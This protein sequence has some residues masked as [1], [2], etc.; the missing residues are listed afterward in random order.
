MSDRLRVAVLMGGPSAEHD[1]SLVSGGAV[2]RTLD[3]SR[4]AP[5]RVE[6]GRDGR[7]SFGPP[8]TDA[9]SAPAE[10]PAADAA[11][12]P[13]DAPMALPAGLER[14]T[15][16]ADVAFIALHGPFGEDGTIQAILEALRMPYTGAGVAASALG[17]DKALFKRLVEALGIP[18]A[19]WIE[20]S[21][22]RWSADPEG[23]LARLEELART[24]G[25]VRLMVKPAALGSS[26]GMTLAHDPVER[27]AA[28]EGAFAHG[29]RALVEGYIAEAR[30]LELAVLGRSHSQ[31]ADD[32]THDATDADVFGPGEI[33]PGREFYDYSAKYDEG[34]SRTTPTAD[35][36]DELRQRV[37]HL[38]LTAFRAIGA[39]GM[40]RID[41]LVQPGRVLL[42]EI[43]TIPG[44]TPISLYPAMVEAGGVSFGELCSRLIQ[45]GLERAR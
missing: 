5:L 9:R 40:A 17:M 37:R 24:T 11:A 26:V 21:R 16:T 4:Y 29:P 14:L 42:S 33:F 41:F 43:N 36:D 44:F 35:V 6:I 3:R 25:D 18:V 45:L 30:E 8:E 15:A 12:A 28:L 2:L 19:P 10:P 31:N 1:V 7:W 34:V 27:P 23:Q 32:T 39:E 13:A 22:T 20:V 38:A